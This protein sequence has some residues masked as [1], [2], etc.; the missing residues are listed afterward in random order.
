MMASIFKWF[1]RVCGVAD[2]PPEF[3]QCEDG[4][5]VLRCSYGQWLACENRLR[6]ENQIRRYLKQH[7]KT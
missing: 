7:P 1:E 5:R 4:C 6:R 3:A 2:L